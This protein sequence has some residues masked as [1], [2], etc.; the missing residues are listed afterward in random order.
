[1]MVYSKTKNEQSII[2]PYHEPFNDHGRS[3]RGTKS[4]VGIGNTAFFKPSRSFNIIRHFQKLLISQ[5]NPKLKPF[6]KP[7]KCTVNSPA[8]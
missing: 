8:D 5:S 2:G 3:R 4:S 7:V 1:M 6:A